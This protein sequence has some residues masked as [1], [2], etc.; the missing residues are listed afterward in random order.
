MD[1]HNQYILVMAAVEDHDLA[2]AGG[3]LVDAPQVVMGQL[4]RGGHFE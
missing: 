4:K 2:F 1:P 3:L